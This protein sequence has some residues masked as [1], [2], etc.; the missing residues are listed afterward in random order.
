MPPT[1]SEASGL[2]TAWNTDSIELPL[3]L[4]NLGIASNLKCSV[5]DA[6][7]LICSLMRIPVN[8]TEEWP[9]RRAGRQ[10]PLTG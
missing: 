1:E 9:G 3:P 10:A 7:D 8:V 6:I 5:W 2:Q 4:K